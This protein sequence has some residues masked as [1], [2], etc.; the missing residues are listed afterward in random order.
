MKKIIEN[1]LL[2][3]E[4]LE[5]PN[6][7]DMLLGPPGTGKSFVNLAIMIKIYHLTN[8]SDKVLTFS[9]SYAAV[10]AILSKITYDLITETDT[11]LSIETKKKAVELFGKIVN[12]NVTNQLFMV[13]GA[14][15]HIHKAE[16]REKI[17]S[18][19][20]KKTSSD[21]DDFQKEKWFEQ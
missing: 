8:R 15:F 4:K 16:D 13:G 5:I 18:M 9:T 14:S 20:N 21:P 7:P 3:E 1:S 11:I 17:I 12:V 10:Y 6:Y 2:T 19:I